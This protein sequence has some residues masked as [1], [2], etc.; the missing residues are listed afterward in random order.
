M[1]PPSFDEQ[2]STLQP[3]TTQNEL[4]L[5]DYVGVVLQRWPIALGIFILVA[6]LTVLYT[7]T[8]I[9]RYTATSRLLLESRGVNLTAMRD[10]YDQGRLAQDDIMQTH[11]Q[12]LTS[13]RVMEAV[14]QSGILSKA[15]D[16]LESRNPVQKLTKMVKASP[17]KAGYVLDVSV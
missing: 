11:I 1:N 10:A 2:E 17:A 15:P 13:P 16:F 7:W 14:L 8:R 3:E 4:H 5:M 12:L 9:P 6:V